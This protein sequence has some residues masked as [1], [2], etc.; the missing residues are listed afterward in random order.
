MF[1]GYFK[2]SISGVTF[3]PKKEFFK[4]LSH[5]YPGLSLGWVSGGGS[6]TLE[7]GFTTNEK[8]FLLVIKYTPAIVISQWLAKIVL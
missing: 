8:L 3:T 4:L 2:S 1:G 7:T 5:T 6:V